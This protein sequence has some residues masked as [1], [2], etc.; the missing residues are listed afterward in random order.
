MDEDLVPGLPLPQ[1]VEVIRHR[2]GPNMLRETCK[3]CDKQRWQDLL[4]GDVYDINAPY[5]YNDPTRDSAK[6]EWVTIDPDSHITR[7]DLRA[8]AFSRVIR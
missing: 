8:Y 3:R 1:G 7:R 4:P 5:G 6:G 2:E